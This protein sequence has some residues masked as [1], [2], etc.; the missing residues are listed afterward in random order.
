MERG[1]AEGERETERENVGYLEWKKKI[2]CMFRNVYMFPSD[3][4]LL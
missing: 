4:P 1:K 3:M 2:L